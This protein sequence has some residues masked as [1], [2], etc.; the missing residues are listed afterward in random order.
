VDEDGV[1]RVEE[2]GG[3][4]GRLPEEAPGDGGREGRRHPVEQGA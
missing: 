2:P 4:A 1:E 3:E